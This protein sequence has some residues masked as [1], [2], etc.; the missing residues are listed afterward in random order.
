MKTSI[1]RLN[2]IQST[3]NTLLVVDRDMLMQL[4]HSGTIGMRKRSSWCGTR[5][6]TITPEAIVKNDVD[7]MLFVVNGKARNM[8]GPNMRD[9]GGYQCHERVDQFDE[10]VGTDWRLSKALHD[11]LDPLN[12]HDR[13]TCVLELP[14]HIVSE[15][16]LEGLEELVRM[17]VR[18][19]GNRLESEK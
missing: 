1:P 8:S 18:E 11:Y 15:Q 13:A 5:L 19:P 14:R 7:R 16:R 9:L 2:G 17:D 12:R 3:K 10:L 6:N 4:A